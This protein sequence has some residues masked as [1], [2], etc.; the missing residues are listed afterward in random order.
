MSIHDYKTSAYISL[1]NP[2]FASLIMAAY[3]KADSDNAV[4]LEEEW[5]EII[6]EL[7]RRY[8]VPGGVLPEEMNADD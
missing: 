5:P 7:R 6:A 4:K 3:R 1:K 2:S 8:H